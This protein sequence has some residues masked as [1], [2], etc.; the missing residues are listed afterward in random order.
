MSFPPNSYTGYSARPRFEGQTPAFT[1]ENTALYPWFKQWNGG[2]HRRTRIY[3]IGPAGLEKPEAFVHQLYGAAFMPPWK[4]TTSTADM[5][6]VAH[7]TQLGGNVDR[8][9]RNEVTV[10][11]GMDAGLVVMA[12]F[13]PALLEDELPNNSN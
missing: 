13:G 11:K 1:I 3:L 6:G 5:V 2:D 12:A 7:A 8:G 9:G 4:F 10:A